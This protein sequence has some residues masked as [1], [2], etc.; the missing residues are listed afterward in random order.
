MPLLFKALFR[1]LLLHPWQF[2]LTLISIASGVM[3]VTGIDIANQSA[4]L[5]FDQANARLNGA[6]THQVKGV[7][8]RIEES[9]FRKLKVELGIRDAAPVISAEVF[10][11]TN[12]QPFTL[13]GIDPL[14]DFRIRQVP[15][16]QAES[17]QP[18]AIVWP[19]FIPASL[20]IDIGDPILLQTAGISQEFT[21]AGFLNTSELADLNTSILVTDIS[22]AQDFLNMERSISY[23]ALKLPPETDAKQIE[24]E[25]PADVQIIDFGVYNNAQKDMTYAFRTNLSALSLL[26]LVIAIFL[27]YSSV[28]FQVA[29]RKKLFAQFRAIGVTSLQLGTL[30]SLEMVVLGLLGTFIGLMTGIWLSET[31]V[32]LIAKTIDTLYFPLKDFSTYL[33]YTVVLKAVLV[34][35]ITTLGACG[36]PIYFASK[37]EPRGMALDFDQAVL[38]STNRLR[39]WWVGLFALIIG[40][41]LLLVPSSSLAFPFIGLFCLIIGLAG[42]TPKIIHGTTLLFSRFNH[43]HRNTLTSFSLSNVRFHLPRIAISVVALS[44]AVSATLGITLMINSFRYSVNDWLE[45]Y[46]TSDIYIRDAS[47]DQ[48]A[49]GSEFINILSALEGVEQVNYGHH[50]QVISD[51]KPLNVFAVYT[52]THGFSGFQITKAISGDLQKAFE[53]QNG[54]LITEPLA[55]SRKLAPSDEITIETDQ[56]TQGF[57]VLGV[58]RDYSSDQG[59]VTMSWNAYEKYFSEPS[60]GSVA[61]KLYE[62]VSTEEVIRQINSLPQLP[63]ILIRSNRALKQ[64]SM[65]IFDQ[66]FEITEVLR[67]LAILVAVVGIVSCLGVLQLQRIRTFSTLNAIGFSRIQL[68]IIG[69]M[70]TLY[71]GVMSGLLAI[72][73]GIV[74]AVSLI[75]VI[76]VRSFGWSITPYFTAE[77]VLLSIGT[78]FIAALLASIYP[79]HRIFKL[80]TIDGIRN[81]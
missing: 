6:A 44:V 49:L 25:L 1:E 54:V 36:L 65:S 27:V 10:T 35:L 76:N 61:I 57:T 72:P 77:P 67:W 8:N 24:A 66:T 81:E 20:G 32:A 26:A 56:G 37:S 51:S 15:L 79:I 16:T 68:S 69:L 23:I 75:Y 80:N 62:N 63:E 58:Y 22:W 70:E 45:K 4:L 60:I 48:D 33:S 18:E 2:L 3:V 39:L 50:F 55:R 43:I 13:L 5:S 7:S 42:F 71:L 12:N 14:S 53:N 74:L 73:I 19:V 38:N 78:A 34:G 17:E 31:L 64:T 47:F 21:V 59:I 52:D 9:V 40:V 41:S 28:S 29:R 11:E 46:L 30:L